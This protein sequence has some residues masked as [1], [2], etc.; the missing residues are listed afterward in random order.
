LASVAKTI[1]DEVDNVHD[2]GY[3]LDGTT[4]GNS[5][6]VFDATGALAVNPLIAADP[7]LVQVAAGPNTSADGS[8]ATKIAALTGGQAAYRDL[9]VKLGVES[10]T[11]SRRSDIQSDITAQVDS[12]SD[13]T[14]G[15]DVDE[16]MTNMLMYQH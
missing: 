2:A 4:T 3:A 5:F 7:T 9:V 8:L 12:A 11:A 14:S 16:E 10:Q 6:F 1:H 13:A 15:V